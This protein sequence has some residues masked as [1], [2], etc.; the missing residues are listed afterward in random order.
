MGV[1]I[2]I[3]CD[4][5]LDGC[6]SGRDDKNIEGLFPGQLSKVEEG[7]K[8]LVLQAYKAG[9]R[10]PKDEIYCPNCLNKLSKL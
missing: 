3:R 4:A 2:E 5:Q 6:V 1:W 8:S 7:Y 10:K 9:W